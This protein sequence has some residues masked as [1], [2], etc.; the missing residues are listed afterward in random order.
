MKIYLWI[1]LFAILL[2]FLF[3]PVFAKVEPK[4]YIN[5]NLLEAKPLIYKGIVY[6]PA[7]VLAETLRVTIRW[8]PS[9]NRLTIEEQS[10]EIEP[11]FYEGGLY[12]PVEAFAEV[13]AIVEWNGREHY[14]K[15]TYPYLATKTQYLSP[16]FTA[17]PVAYTYSPTP[18]PYI[19]QQVAPSPTPTPYIYQPVTTYYTT[20][21][22][23]TS[24]LT[25]TP[26]SSVEISTAPPF[27]IPKS[28]SN[29]IF[30]VTVTNI[31]YT[32]V[33]KH[34][35]TPRPGYKF[36]IINVSQQN[37][38]P[39]VQI[40][41]GTFS[42]FDQEGHSYDYLEG[43]S[44]YW[45]QILQPGGTNFGHLVYEIPDDAVPD[46]LVLYSINNPTLVLDLY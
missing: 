4:I 39:S 16:T 30:N 11:Y 40:Y 26:S 35:Y 17:T 8:D 29:G 32:N 21:T 36:C 13:G 6:L 3:S 1:I 46:R 18:T 20:P 10:I 41:T 19:Y 43:L 42:L 23:L 33:I 34:Y 38:S 7:Q 2:F 14:V 9:A 44:N 5:N 31:E 28:V 12:I 27:F 45:L 24:I 25:P 22:P 37:I 15:I